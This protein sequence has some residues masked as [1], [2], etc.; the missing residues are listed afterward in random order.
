MSSILVV[1][2]LM[3]ANPGAPP[4]LVNSFAKSAD[5]AAALTALPATPQSQCVMYV[6]KRPG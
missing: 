6:K 5:C 2:V 1:W 3:T 4:T